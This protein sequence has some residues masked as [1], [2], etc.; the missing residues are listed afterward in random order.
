[1]IIYASVCLEKNSSILKKAEK[2]LDP[3][4]NVYLMRLREN[5]LTGKEV[6]SEQSDCSMAVRML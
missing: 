5:R 2:Y 4:R 1:M 3:V 6:G